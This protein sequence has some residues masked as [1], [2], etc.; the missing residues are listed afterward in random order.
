MGIGKEKIKPSLF[1]DN[2]IAYVENTK[3]STEN[4]LKLISDFRKSAGYKKMYKSN[5][6]LYSRNEQL[7]IEQFTMTM[8]TKYLAGKLTK[9]VQNLYTENWKTLRGIKESP[10]KW[11]EI[12]LV[13]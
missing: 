3:E 11:R 5:V 8:K 13:N 9:Y 10:N 4:L 7:E 6:F 1:T 12:L 2:T